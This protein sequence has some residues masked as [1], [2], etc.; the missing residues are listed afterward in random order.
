M[1]RYCMIDYE[2]IYY[3]IISVICFLTLGLQTSEV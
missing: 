3:K 1:N 2:I